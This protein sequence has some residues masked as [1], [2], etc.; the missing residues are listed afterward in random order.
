MHFCYWFSTKLPKSQN[1]KKKSQNIF[2]NQNLDLKVSGAQKD[3]LENIFPKFDAVVTIRSALFVVAK[4]IGGNHQKN[5]VWVRF[6]ISRLYIY[7]NKTWIQYCWRYFCSSEHMWVWN[8]FNIFPQ[9]SRI[10]LEKVAK[11]PWFTLILKKQKKN[12][13]KIF[14]QKSFGLNQKLCPLVCLKTN[15]DHM[16]VFFFHRPWEPTKTGSEHLI[17]E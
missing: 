4:K 9:L 17:F 8:L 10:L 16:E 13:N 3:C 2:F 7:L 12:F 15:Y 11:N 5:S 14:F 6:Q 1:F